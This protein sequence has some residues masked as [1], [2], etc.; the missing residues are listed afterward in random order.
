MVVGNE[1][2]QTQKYFFFYPAQYDSNHHEE[3]DTKLPDYDNFAF[4]VH[5]LSKPKKLVSNLFIN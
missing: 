5:F 4:T 2:S 1:R 3:I